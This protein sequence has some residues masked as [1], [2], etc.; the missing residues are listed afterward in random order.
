MNLE[1]EE[2]RKKIDSQLANFLD[3]GG[4]IQKIPG[5]VTGDKRV[6]AN[7]H[8]YKSAFTFNRWTENKKE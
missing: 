8:P 3:S 1:K 5:G 7:G 6:L 2:S 4:K